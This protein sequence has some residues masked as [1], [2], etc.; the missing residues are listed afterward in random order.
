MNTASLEIHTTRAEL[1]IVTQKAK[2][3]IRRRR[4]VL[5]IVRTK[6][7]MHIDRKLPT[8]RLNRA[9]LQ[10]MLYRGPMLQ[11]NLQYFQDALQRG[12]RPS[13]ASPARATR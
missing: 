2:V 13:P 4:P 9:Q 1:E 8:M 6:P 10:R 7:V 12:W 5:N 3:M 11:G